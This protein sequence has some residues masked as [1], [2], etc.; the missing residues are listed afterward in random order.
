MIFKV[1]H[2][3]LR[4]NVCLIDYMDLMATLVSGTTCIKRYRTY[5]KYREEGESRRTSI[6]I[7]RCPVANHFSV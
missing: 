3:I 5:E 7:S 4:Y 2:T 1:H 6:I